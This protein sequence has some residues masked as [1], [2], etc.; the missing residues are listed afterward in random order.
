VIGAG[1]SDI[2]LLSVLLIGALVN[3]TA[4]NSIYL[5]EQTNCK[6]LFRQCEVANTR[7]LAVFHEILCANYEQNRRLTKDTKCDS[8]KRLVR[9]LYVCRCRTKNGSIFGFFLISGRLHDE[10]TLEDK[11]SPHISS[12]YDKKAK[13]V[14]RQKKGRNFW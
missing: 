5:V 10:D 12:D 13:R 11:L 2:R 8:A 7:I 1:A 4:F 3:C 14:D 6:Y 9:N